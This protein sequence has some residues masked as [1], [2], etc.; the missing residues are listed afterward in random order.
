M[1][2]TTSSTPRASI[3]DTSSTVRQGSEDSKTNLLQVP[4]VNT[5]QPTTTTQNQSEQRR[6]STPTTASNRSTSRGRLSV[7]NSSPNSRRTSVSNSGKPRKR[8][9]FWRSG[10]F[11]E[12]GQHSPEGGAKV[13]AM[14]QSVDTTHPEVVEEQM[15]AMYPQWRN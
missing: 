6:P 2:D 14:S 15:R 5:T 9:I 8:D 11:D 12:K 1:L 3:D 10:L 4:D 7:D 13:R